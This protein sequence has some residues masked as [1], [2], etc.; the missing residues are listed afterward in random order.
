MVTARANSSAGPPCFFSGQAQR[1]RQGA[2]PPPIKFRRVQLCPTDSATSD[3]NPATSGGG[4]D[5]TNS[6]EPGSSGDYLCSS[7]WFG[8]QR[9]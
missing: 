2:L 5:P 8:Q 3:S 7:D 1:R 4:S 9:G 6:G